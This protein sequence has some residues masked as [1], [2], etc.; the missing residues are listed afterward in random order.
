MQP[1]GRTQFT[2]HLHHLAIPC[3]LALGHDV[4]TVTVGDETAICCQES[5]FALR[6]NRKKNRGGG[7]RLDRIAVGLVVVTGMKGCLIFDVKESQGCAG[8]VVYRFNKASRRAVRYCD[9]V[10]AFC[11]IN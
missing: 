6:Q 5:H 2:H 3:C 11:I 1:C 8:Q 10:D 4:P 9:K 7:S